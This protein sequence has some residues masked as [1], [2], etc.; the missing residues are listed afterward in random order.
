MPTANM[1]GDHPF[2][3]HM[4]GDPGQTARAAVEEL[5]FLSQAAHSIRNKRAILRMASMLAQLAADL[6]EAWRNKVGEF[7]LPYWEL[8]TVQELLGIDPSDEDAAI[9][10]TLSAL[11]SLANGLVEAVRA[12]RVQTALFGQCIERLT[13]WIG[14]RLTMPP[15]AH[16]A[17]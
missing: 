3:L 12:G 13:P 14:V 7:K 15:P 9:G 4:G 16:T 17:A 10:D 2:H 5:G 8:Y 11:E 6:F 1:V